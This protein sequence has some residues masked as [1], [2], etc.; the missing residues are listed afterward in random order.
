MS[1]ID[2]LV[3]FIDLTE[4]TVPLDEFSADERGAL[5]TINQRVASGESLSD[6]MD[7]VFESTLDLFPCDRLSIAFVQEDDRVVSHW[8]RALYSPLLLHNGYA[9]DLRQTTL[10]HVR[11]SGHVRII[12]D[13]EAY[14]EAKR[15]SPSSRLLVRE[16]VRSSMTCPLSVEGRNVGFLFRSS[17]KPRSYGMHEVLLHSALAGRLSQAVE[18]AYRIEQLT[19]AN[20]AYTE[21]LGFI[22]H[23]LKS[24]LGSIVMDLNVL[25]DGYLGKIEPPQRERIEKTRGKAQYLLTLIKDYLDLARIEGG[26]FN[27]QPQSAVD[28]LDDVLEP[29]LTV[30]RS[31][32]EERHMKLERQVPEK[33]LKIECD[34]GLLNIVMVN[35]LSNAVKYGNEAGRIRVRIEKP[36]GKLAVSVWNEGP[37]FPKSERSK[38]FKKFSRLQTKELME[39]KGTGVGL[40]TTW[41]IIQA[42][43]GRTWAD[44]EEGSWAEFHFE[45]PQPLRQ[46]NKP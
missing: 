25:E 3:R 6:V 38:L 35:L 34:P 7:F 41:R 9:E 16:G 17:R 42:H 15:Q 45:I 40:Y 18:K 29:A 19:A 31:E 10:A 43:G 1:I 8:S 46:N 21:M 28:F 24:P 14:V 27:L 39:R 13:L 32:M 37:G 2:K 36:D 12:D 26:G 11:D 44:S 33:P 5:D 4:V 30:V 22:S 20:R 23:E